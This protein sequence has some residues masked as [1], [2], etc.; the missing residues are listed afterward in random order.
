[1]Q[2]AVIADSHIPDRADAIPEEFRERIADA[3]HVIH[4]GD[5]E[6]REVLDDIH[7]LATDLTAVHGNCDPAD[8]GLPAVADLTVEGVTFVVTHGTI[9]HVEAA[10]YGHDAVVMSDEAWRQAV[11]DTARTRTRQWDGDGIV[12]IGGHSHSVVDEVFEDVRLLNPGTVTG[13]NP[14]DDTTMMTVEVEDGGID[15][16]LH[17]F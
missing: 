6:T 16:T 2:L 11:A 1:M 5:V 9:D 7:D 13:A 17:E 10:V 12:G 4:A 3:D 8:I 14:D 15:V